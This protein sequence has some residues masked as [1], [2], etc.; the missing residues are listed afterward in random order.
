MFALEHWLLVQIKINSFAVTI[1]IVISIYFSD[2]MHNKRLTQLYL[3]AFLGTH[4]LETQQEG[5]YNTFCN[6]F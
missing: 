2:Y 3:I 5:G 6:H 1:E 4:F